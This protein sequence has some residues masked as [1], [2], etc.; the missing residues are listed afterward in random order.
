MHANGHRNYRIWH[1]HHRKARKRLAGVAVLTP[2]LESSFLNDLVGGRLL[3]KA[4]PLQRTGSFKFR[5]AYNRI[6][7]IAEDERGRGVVAFS[8]GNHAQG[9]A[10]AAQLSGI[11]TCIVM[12]ADAPE[13]KLENTRAYGA[14][15]ITYDRYSEDREAVAADVLKRTGGT[16]VRPFDDAGVIAGQGTI[17]YEIAE[18]CRE[19]RAE[20]DQVIICCGGGGLTAGCATALQDVIPGLAIYS[21]EPDGF[22]DTARSLV[23]GHRLGNDPTARSV[24]DALL[25]ERPGELTFAVNSRRLSG[26][27][28]VRDEE[29]FM[30]MRHAFDRLKLVI[31]PGGAVALAAALAGRLETQGRTTVVV[32]SGGNV[33]ADMFRRALD[34]AG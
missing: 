16:L 25:S 20:P 28:V 2:L 34:A 27:L 1:Q 12:P 24:C 7:Q 17:G 5:G 33:D 32:A 11:P 23:A 21:A 8:S 31:E 14:E 6:A 4:E 19:Q 10:H 29:V 18:Q 3:V 9:V 15:V 26:G 22:D 13:M 30:A